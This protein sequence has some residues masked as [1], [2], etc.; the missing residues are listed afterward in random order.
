MRVAKNLRALREKRG[1]TQEQLAH[2]SG[3][4]PRHLQK[5]EAGEVNLTLNTISKLCAAL[6]ID[7]QALFMPNEVAR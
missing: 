3:M 2:H 1:L 6:S 5:A 7:A 4:A